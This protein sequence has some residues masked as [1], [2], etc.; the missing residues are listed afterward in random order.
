MTFVKNTT[1]DKLK[2][3]QKHP[4]YEDK[5]EI[6]RNGVKVRGTLI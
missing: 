4:V 1:V 3:R 2:M 6:R 5:S